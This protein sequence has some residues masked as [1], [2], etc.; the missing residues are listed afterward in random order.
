[1]NFKA[2]EFKGVDWIYLT[3]DRVQCRALVNSTKNL[4][5]S[6]KDGKFLDQVN[7]C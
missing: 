4:R 5:G 6:I 7:D 2:I 1:M 3:Q